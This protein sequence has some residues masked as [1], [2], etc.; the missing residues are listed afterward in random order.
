MDNTA[1]TALT[2]MEIL[3]SR[4]N[5]TVKCTVRLQSGASGTA[6]VPSGASTGT[7]EALELRDGDKARYLGKGVLNALNNI[8]SVIAPAVIGLDA[9]DQNGLD[10][11]MLNLD[12][13]PSKSKL[14]ANAILAVSM[15]AACAAAAHRGIPLY[16]S[17]NKNENYLL[18][19]PMI[20]ILNGGSHADNNV[21][22]QEFMIVPL[23]L[24]SFKEAIRAAAE[25]FQNLKKIL[26]RKSYSTSVGDEGGFAPNLKS[27]EEAID[28]ILE[29]IVQAGYTPAR[30]ISL[31]LDAAATEFFRDGAYVFDKSDGSRKS[32]EEM[33]TFY[34]KLI[35]AYPIIS[36][37]DGCAEDDWEGWALL[38]RELGHSIQLVGDDLFV[39]NRERFQEGID[40]GITNSILIKLNQIGTLSE[41]VSV[42]RQAHE[43]G[44]SSV[45]SHRSGETEDTFIADLSVALHTGQ[46]KTG[47]V[48]RSER[49][50]K[51]NRLL[52]IEGE[53]GSRGRYSG[54]DSY[55]KYLHPG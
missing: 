43:N 12:G 15:A 47:S 41:T 20:N 46:I 6:A 16:A 33:V 21:D 35:T 14:G 31:A 32:A 55:K 38:T 8:D 22:I 19:V 53:L 29:S 44:Y 5:P 17:L 48:C 7:H 34:K 10:R 51:Y 9:M 3:D 13:T 18:P 25:V 24:P 27:N 45:I 36:I 37:E 40:R 23:G 1:I 11:T 39:T 52:E 42:I 2:G 50:A 54:M 30:D 28:V 26:K 49:V 4:G